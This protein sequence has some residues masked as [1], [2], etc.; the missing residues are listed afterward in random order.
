[1]AFFNE[2]QWTEEPL[3]PRVPNPVWES[4]VTSIMG[5]LPDCLQRL[6]PSP[7]RATTPRWNA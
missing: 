5:M 3:V 4:E 1:M 6:S 2:L 7:W